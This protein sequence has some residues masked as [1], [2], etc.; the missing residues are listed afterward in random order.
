MEIKSRSPQPAHER[1]QCKRL[2]PSRLYNSR[3]KFYSAADGGNV[4]GDLNIGG[5]YPLR[6]LHQ[7]DGRSHPGHDFH[8]PRRFSITPSIRYVLYSTSYVDNSLED[9][10]LL[11]GVILATHCTITLTSVP[12]NT[13]DQGSTCADYQARYGF[14]PSV[15]ANYRPLPWLTFYGGYRKPSVVRHW[16]VAAACSKASTLQLSPVPGPLWSVRP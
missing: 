12:G 7:N 16:A 3:N 15:S 2:F 11:P 4:R 6:L 5:K 14:E 10:H 8:P 13:T 1:S 9:F